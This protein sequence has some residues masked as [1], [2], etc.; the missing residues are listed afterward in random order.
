MSPKKPPSEMR[1]PD[2]EYRQDIAMPTEEEWAEADRWLERN[3]DALNESI[4]RSDEEFA[5]GEY[6]TH[7]EVMAHIKALI[8][9]Y[10]SNK[11]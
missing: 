8:A 2:V 11:G 9:Q 10:R 4:R 6:Y 1:E 3:K 5:R 7:E